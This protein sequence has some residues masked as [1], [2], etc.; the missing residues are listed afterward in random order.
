VVLDQPAFCRGMVSVFSSK[1]VEWTW[2][3]FSYLYIYRIEVRTYMMFV[4]LIKNAIVQTWLELTFT[5][6]IHI[7]IINTQYTDYSVP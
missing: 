7:I 5:K 6:A 4:K 1:T 3:F 2:C